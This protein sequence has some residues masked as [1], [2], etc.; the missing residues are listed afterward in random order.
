MQGNVKQL[1]SRGPERK[2]NQTGDQKTPHNMT[3]Q[4]NCNLLEKKTPEEIPREASSSLQYSVL[5]LSPDVV[6][7][8]VV[9]A[10]YPFCL[11]FRAR[12]TGG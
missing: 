12:Y 6:N 8:T 5:A 7:K 11:W 9:V 3:L 10:L 2:I 1:Q 4:E